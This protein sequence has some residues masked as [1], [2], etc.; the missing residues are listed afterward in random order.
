MCIISIIIS[1]KES[2]F[3]VSDSRDPLSLSWDQSAITRQYSQLDTN[4]TS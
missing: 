1:I 2:T 4:A 3:C